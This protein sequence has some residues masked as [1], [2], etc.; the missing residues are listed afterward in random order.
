LQLKNDT[1]ER[2]TFYLQYRTSDDPT[3]L[4]GDD[5][6]KC[7]V[8]AGDTKFVLDGRNAPLQAN[9]VRIQYKLPGDKDWNL[10]EVGLADDNVQPDSMTV[11]FVFTDKVQ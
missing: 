11:T 2:L 9:R 4:P 7:E 10:Q 6:L 1:K 8:D 3:W 5:G